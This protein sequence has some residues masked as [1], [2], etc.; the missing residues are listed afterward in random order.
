MFERHHDKKV[1]KE[2]DD[3]LSHWQ[4]RRDGYANYLELAK[5]YEGEASSEIMLKPSEAV[6]AQVTSGSLVEDRRGPGHWQGGSAGISVPVGSIGGHSVR[7]RV[8]A[9]RG[10]YAQGTPTPTAI[11]TGTVY[12][13]NRRVV[14]QGVKQ[15]R[16]CLFDKLIGFQHDDQDGTTVFSVSNRQKAITI[17]YGQQLSAWF[18]FRLDLAL[19]HYRD[20]VGELINQLKTELASLDASKPLPPA[21]VAG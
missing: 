15:T 11:D 9:T 10:H 14:F 4:T 2:F 17:H 7:Y 19:A 21:P 5:S 8:G 12:V 18:D 16:E 20:T 3:K 1:V 13:T 6:F